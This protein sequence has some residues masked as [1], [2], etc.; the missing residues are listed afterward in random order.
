MRLIKITIKSITKFQL[1]KIY[2]WF[3]DKE[4]SRYLRTGHRTMKRI[5]EILSR[6]ETH[7]FIINEDDIDIG[8]IYITKQ[9]NFVSLTIL[10]D[11]K[12]WGRGYGKQ[13]MI[14]IEDKAKKLKAKKII[15]GLYKENER[16]YN[17][18]KHLGYTIT[19]KEENKII[20]MKK[21]IKNF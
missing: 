18:Y 12:Y 21:I 5:I 14:L 15:F 20:V 13:A 19:K 8:Y 4:M 17:L 16:A 10:I 9:D 7:N 6:P 3:N 11:K 2:R 1:Q